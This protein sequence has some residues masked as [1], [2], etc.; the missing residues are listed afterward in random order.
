M[1][2]VL[3]L[4]HGPSIESVS[5]G[6]VS[7]CKRKSATASTY[8][9]NPTPSSAVGWSLTF[10]TC[11]IDSSGTESARSKTLPIRLTAA[12]TSSSASDKSCQIFPDD[13]DTGA[14]FGASTRASGGTYTV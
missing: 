4:P 13:L 2:D 7:S 6:V 9:L 10:R 3:P 14:G 1:N 11:G 8:G 5:G 12:T